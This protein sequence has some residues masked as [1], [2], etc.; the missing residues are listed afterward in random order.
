MNDPE[1]EN[2]LR[3]LR[4]ASPSMSLEGRIAASMP[5][6]IHEPASNPWLARMM[7]RILWMASGATA[8]WL[9]GVTL[10]PAVLPETKL[11]TAPVE[12]PAARPVRVTEEALP[13]SDEGVRFVDGQTP[14]RVWRRAV[15]E[16]H[17]S[18]DGAGEVRVPREDMVVLPVALR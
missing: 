13:W 6:T 5:D 18:P 11:A 3:G 16:R 9:A 2:K 1:F 7:D 8:M 12:K 10:K 4:P 17:I 14:A 15:M